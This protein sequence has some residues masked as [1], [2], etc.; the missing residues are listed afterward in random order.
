[1][2]S[3]SSQSVSEIFDEVPS[4]PMTYNPPIDGYTFPDPQFI[5]KKEDSR[6]FQEFI[7]FM[8]FTLDAQAREAQA[9]E[10]DEQQTTLVSNTDPFESKVNEILAPLP[11]KRMATRRGTLKFDFPKKIVTQPYELR[12]DTPFCIGKTENTDKNA[13][14]LMFQMDEDLVEDLVDALPEQ[15]PPERVFEM[16]APKPSKKRN[17]EQDERSKKPKTK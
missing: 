6:A 8:A 17:L 15:A 11:E 7:A 4:L 5:M 16:P 3:V 14:Q 10:S 9:L 13:N 1:M 2:G 12:N